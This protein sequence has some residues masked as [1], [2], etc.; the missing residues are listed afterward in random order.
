MMPPSGF[1]SGDEQVDAVQTPGNVPA[2]PALSHT[3]PSPW[4]MSG[5][6]TSALARTEIRQSAQTA[7]ATECL[8]IERKGASR[9]VRNCK[10][11]SAG[12]YSASCEC[13]RQPFR[14]VRSCAKRLRGRSLGSAA[15]PRARVS[16][17]CGVV[18]AGSLRASGVTE[19]REDAMEG[20]ASK[21]PAGPEHK[22]ASFE[23][24]HTSN[25]PQLFERAGISLVVSTYQAGMVILV[26]REGATL[27][28]HFRVFDK[29]M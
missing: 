29:P 11:R 10:C 1:G 25:L 2:G 9:S 17:R 19:R 28:T 13:R 5:G 26:R 16:P 21:D 3:V 8:R 20:E 6:A 12:R 7:R 27:N 18:E 22:A 14:S 24:V 15:C 4:Q 23:S